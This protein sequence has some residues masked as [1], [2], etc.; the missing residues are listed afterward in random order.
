MSKQP[1]VKTTRQKERA[2]ILAGLEAV[3]YV[4]V[5]SEPTPEKLIH[6]I[7]PDVLVKGGDWKKKDIVGSDFVEANGGKVYSLPYVKDR[8]TTGLIARIRKAL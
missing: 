8:S 6:A 3:D 1:F 7:I 4:T 2:E 5:F